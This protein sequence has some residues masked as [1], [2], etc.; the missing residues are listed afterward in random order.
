[1][2]ALPENVTESI[3]SDARPAL[4]LDT[5]PEPGSLVEHHR[6]VQAAVAPDHH[7]A[8]DDDVRLEPASLPNRRAVLDH[9]VRPD[10]HAVRQ[11]DATTEHRRRMDT[12]CARRRRI[13][14]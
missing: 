12:R 14:A 4:Y 2:G 3:R 5:V 10:R 6:G 1:M 9:D 13:E 7:V 11:G 8:P